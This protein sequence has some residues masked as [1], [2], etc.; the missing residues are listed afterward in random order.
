MAKNPQQV[1]KKWVSRLGVSQ[2]E[3]R[4]GVQAVTVAPSTKAIQKK[5]KMVARWMEAVNSGKWE[6][7]LG[8]VTLED[9]R[10][11]MLTK[12]INR[13]GTGAA[14]AE[15]KFAAFMTDLLAYQSNLQNQVNSMPDFNLAD[16][17]QR[18]LAWMEGMSKFKRS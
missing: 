3:I 12:G 2:E 1:A 6:R 15:G 14:A 17:G 4:Q 7:N 9:W 10:Q 8:K 5:D 18:M 16:S 11:A 13:I